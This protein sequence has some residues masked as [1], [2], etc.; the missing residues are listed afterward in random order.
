MTLIVQLK[1]AQQAAGVAEPNMIINSQSDQVDIWDDL[2][3]DPVTNNNAEFTADP[4]IT[5]PAAS[6]ESGKKNE[7]IGPVTIEN[8]T[9][10]LPSNGNTSLVYRDL[11]ISHRI[12][13]AE[14]QLNHIRNL[15]AEKSFQFSHV[16]RISHRKG[17][18][19][20]SRAL[21]KRLNN[22]IAEHGQMYT[23]CRASLLL[24][25][26]DES[27]MTRFKVLTPSDI[28][29]STIVINPNAPGS[30]RISL[31]WI[32]QTAARH[33]LSFTGTSSDIAEMMD[34][35]QTHVIDHSSLL[36]CTLMSLRYID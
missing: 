4:G 32:W 36:E 12:S 34:S 33:V 3:F 23:R 18:T 22:Q 10:A 1:Q 11:E 16:I 7:I 19:T 6:S 28:N 26:A 14:E 8:Q 24:L 21:V 25:N 17:V 31:S 29:A 2:A 20:R 15:I 5:N 13:I 35:S 9:I 30:T 27:I